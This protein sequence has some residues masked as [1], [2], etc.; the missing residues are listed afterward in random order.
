MNHHRTLTVATYNICH[1]HYANF[2][3]ARIAAPIRSLDP[4]FVGIQ[5]VDM[6]TNRSR[7][8][9]TL[10]ALASATG[11][12]Y[13]LFV[14]TMEFD[15]GK[16]GIALLSRHPILEAETISLPFDGYEP[17]TAGCIRVLVDGEHPL[18]FVNTHLS[19]ISDETRREQ[20]SELSVRLRELISADV[21][22]ILSGDFNTEERLSPLVDNAFSDINEDG[23]CLTFREPPLAI[24]RI[25][26]TP[27][28]LTPLDHGMVE[29]AASDHNLLWAKFILTRNDKSPAAP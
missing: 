23:R 14:P 25:A 26:Y 3:W 7:K 16:Y 1:G 22:A 17:R 21:P 8:I 5:E 13:A 4:D 2:D 12:P 29:S 27:A 20:L 11:M 10:A 9:D 6:F 18:W 28:H 19:Y 15:G 24:D